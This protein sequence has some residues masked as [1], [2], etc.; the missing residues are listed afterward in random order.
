ML[1]MNS[2]GMVAWV[3]VFLHLLNV[4]IMLQLLTYFKHVFNQALTEVFK[5][6]IV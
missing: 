5:L 6:F 3:C 2:C 4:L 1:F